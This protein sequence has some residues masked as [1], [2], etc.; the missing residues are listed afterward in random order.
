MF[1]IF[2]MVY[3]GMVRVHIVLI[4]AAIA[5]IISYAAYTA[6]GSM[7]VLAYT[8]WNLGNTSIKYYK[9]LSGK[10]YFDLRIR[11]EGIAARP[12]SATTSVYGWAPNGS[13]IYLGRYKLSYSYGLLITKLSKVK[14]LN[15]YAEWV[16]WAKQKGI[17]P[18]EF[19]VPIILIN[20]LIYKNKGLY[21]FAKSVTINPERATKQ[22]I[23]INIH[24]KLNKAGPLMSWTE[25]KN[26]IAFALH[27]HTPQPSLNS[28]G[29][30]SVSEF[31]PGT[32]NNDVLSEWRLITY[33]I[34]Y[35]RHL[36]LAAVYLHGPDLYAVNDVDLSANLVAD[37]SRKLK[38]TFSMGGFKFEMSSGSIEPKGYEIPGPSFELT[39]TKS[40]LTVS[41]RVDSTSNPIAGPSSGC[42][43]EGLS[44]HCYMD[45]WGGS[46]TIEWRSMKDDVPHLISIGF[47]GDIAIAEYRLGF[48]VYDP[49]NNRY[50]FVFSNTYMNVTMVRPYVIRNS[51]GVVWGWAELDPAPFDDSIAWPAVDKITYYWDYVD[52][53]ELDH[54]FMV[55]SYS[56]SERILTI[57]ILSAGVG[58][59]INDKIE[60]NLLGVGV[61][62]TYQSKTLSMASIIVGIDSD[63]VGDGFCELWPWLYKSPVKYE[64]DGEL[65]PIGIMYAD[66]Y[67]DITPCS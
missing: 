36:P 61:G 50:V 55:S 18:A 23:E 37:S 52:Y 2:I 31:P 19:N 45:I 60:A 7:K 67:V 65:H 46:A 8:D 33:K 20:T 38:V 14:M 21:S 47:R 29:L 27:V 58:L 40:W 48:W 3:K 49:D 34:Y 1:S 28:Q 56:Y 39:G 24:Q 64:I 15:Y 62:L 41:L 54:A 63:K 26:T 4:A 44:Y 30:S 59:P 66:V 5:I 42:A 35:N 25:V 6:I 16:K 32:I 51:G 53:G 10:Q 13:I 9:F 11:I 12:L 43:T 22:A 57:P 17:S